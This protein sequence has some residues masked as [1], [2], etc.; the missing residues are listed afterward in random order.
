[1]PH[2]LGVGGMR[3]IAEGSASRA[4][5]G[6]RSRPRGRPT[7]DTAA[8]ID[9]EILD[10]ALHLFLKN[11]F[12]QTS[13]ATIIK[14]AGVSKTTLYARYATKADLFRA[15]VSRT[16][17]ETQNTTLSSGAEL[18]HDLIE[19]LTAHGIAGIRIGLLPLWSNYERLVYSEGPRFP[20]LA[21][22]ITERIEF[23]VQ[24]V[25]RFIREAAERDGIPC[26]DPHSVARIYIMALRGFYSELVLS[27]RIA[28]LDEITQFVSELIRSL[29]SARK[30]W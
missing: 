6:A 21:Q 14:A 29:I 25:A 2:G 12:G 22:S 17:Q 4:H 20:E 9:R 5:N 24:T 18:T 7:P 11:G 8:Q 23:G 13:M 15:I 19:G 1:M 30:D 26:R 3:K 27:A 28:P 10:A 16:V